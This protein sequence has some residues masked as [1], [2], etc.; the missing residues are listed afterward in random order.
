MATSVLSAGKIRP[1]QT[2]LR[3]SRY[4][5]RDLPD[6]W[7][8]YLS[9]S[10]QPVT[11]LVVFVHGFG[12]KAVCTW[13]DFPSLD[14]GVQE[15]VWWRGADLLFIGYQSTRDSIT[16]VANRI[17]SQLPRFYPVPYRQAL[18]VDGIPL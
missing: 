8:L 5:S 11:R 9:P 1:T 12:G 4:D 18:E 2:F 17:R 7:V 10:E 15:N 14:L 3:Y 6:R 13:L 16:A